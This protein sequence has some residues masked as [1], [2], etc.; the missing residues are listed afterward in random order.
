MPDGLKDAHQRAYAKLTTYLHVTGRR[1]DGYHLL[2]AEMVSLD[3]CDELRFGQ[4]DR[5]RVTGRDAE[6]VPT[7]ATN[8]VVRALRSAGVSA[9]VA[10]D[11]AIPAGAGLGGGSSDAAAALRYAGE[12]DPLV[13][14]SVGAD[15]PFCLRGGR[16]RVTGVGE[17]LEP[18]TYEERVYTLMVPPFGV[19]TAEAYRQY[20]RI[21]PAKSAAEDPRNHLWLAARTVEPRLTSW[22]EKIGEHTGAVPVLAGSGST[23][24]VEGEF[25]EPPADFPPEAVW[26][27][28]R[29]TKRLTL[30]E[31]D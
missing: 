6:R 17:K 29:T 1:P 14:A 30:T 8:L 11:K 25:P 3:F 28:A 10:I 7:D 16:A 13:A 21:D 19:N 9:S 22:R 24:F 18:L 31:P 20:D 27:V 23:M 4:G 26:R 5:V 12:L 15:V 2:D